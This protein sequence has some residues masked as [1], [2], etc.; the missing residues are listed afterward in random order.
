[1]LGLKVENK[2]LQVYVVG[3]ARKPLKPQKTSSTPEG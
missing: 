2:K 1:M 3:I